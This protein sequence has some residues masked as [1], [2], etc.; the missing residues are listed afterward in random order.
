M[1]IAANIISIIILIVIV[2]GLIT[3]IKEIHNEYT[4]TNDGL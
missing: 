1:G 3:S 4:D 2:S